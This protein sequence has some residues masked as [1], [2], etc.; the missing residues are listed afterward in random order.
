M[1]FPSEGSLEALWNGNLGDDLTI[2]T[3]TDSSADSYGEKNRAY[4]AGTA[5]RGRMKIL[6]AN[7]V[8]KEFGYMR[9][10]DAIALLKLTATIAQN[11]LIVHNSITYAVIGIVQ[12][13]T[14]QEVACRRVD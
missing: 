12:K 10:G 8:N 1:A 7:E 11:D 9:P 4:S 5:A 2:K 13:K 14:H 6:Q 3:A